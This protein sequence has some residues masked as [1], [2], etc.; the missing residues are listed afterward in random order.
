MERARMRNLNIQRKLDLKISDIHNGQN[1]QMSRI[2]AEQKH[3][4]RVLQEMKDARRREMQGR[5]IL[6]RGLSDRHVQ[7]L[8]DAREEAAGTSISLGEFD[9]KMAKFKDKRRV[10]RNNWQKY[11]CSGRGADGSG[12]S[13][14]HVAERCIVTNVHF[15]PYSKADKDKSLIRHLQMLNIDA[16]SLLPARFYC[17]E[18]ED[19]EETSEMAQSS[20]DSPLPLMDANELQRNHTTYEPS[21]ASQSSPNLKSIQCDPNKEDAFEGVMFDTSKPVDCAGDTND[22]PS[23]PRSGTPESNAIARGFTMS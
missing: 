21:K 23:D 5:A 8:R 22:V 17:E 9:K 7:M 4:K 6:P 20:T 13:S 14:L 10:F 3:L 19:D 11:A 12:R 18:D 1:V 15:N 16:P 2:A